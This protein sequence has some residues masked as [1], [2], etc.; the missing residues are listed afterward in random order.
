M[1]PAPEDNRFHWSI[2]ILGYL[3]ALSL[4]LVAGLA[5]VVAFGHQNTASKDLPLWLVALGQVPLWLLFLGVTWFVSRERG[6][7]R[8]RDDYG[9]HFTRSDVIGIPIGIVLQVVFVPALY[10][11]LRMIDGLKTTFSEANLEAPA[12]ELTDKGRQGFGVVLLALI[13]VLGA[14]FFEELFYRGLVLRSFQA[15]HRD[16]LALVASSA[17]FALAHFQDVQLPGLFLFGLVAGYAAQRTGRLG[18][19]MAIHLGFNAT[20]VVNLLWLNS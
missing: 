13:L 4:A 8:F 12:R 15:A 11:G 6:T 16:G 9:L 2:G 19:S 17:M 18:L 3:V 14:P 5:L 20:A 10:A 1:R 7:G